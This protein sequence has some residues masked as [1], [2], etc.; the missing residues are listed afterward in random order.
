MRA[1]HRT[2]S[3]V[4]LLATAVAVPAVAQTGGAP[5]TNYPVCTTTPTKQDSEQAHSAFL[6]GKRFFDEADYG[7][8]IH[9]FVDAYKLDCMK[10]ELLTIVARAHE[11]NGNRPE[12]VHALETY[13]QRAPSIS[14]DDKGQI[15]KR[16]DNLKAQIAAQQ[17]SVTASATAVTP[18][19]TAPTSTATASSTAPAPPSPQEHTV[20]PWLVVGVGATAVL[21]GGILFLVER[22][23]Q[24]TA[25]TKCAN[26][27]K[28]CTSGDVS[29]ARL[30][31]DSASNLVT[32]GSIVL[33]SG[34]GLTAAGLFW[35]FLEPTGPK[36]DGRARVSPAVAPGYAGL[37]LGGA[38]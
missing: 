35:H 29:S 32:V 31:Y 21:V 9:N 3:L 30:D 18:T 27:A 25:A 33:W 4:A 17:P 20:Y 11:L 13:L 28:A 6:I 12:A 14:A 2:L 7:S 38:F 10:P 26:P 15:Q 23:A 24:N 37:S 1:S 34:V 19:A 22:S 16:I 36:T 5:L 8:A